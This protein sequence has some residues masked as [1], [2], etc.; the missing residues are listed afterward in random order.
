[1]AS[2]PE[3][4]DH[5]DVMIFSHG[6]FSR[7]FIARWCDLPLQAGYHFAADAGGVSFSFCNLDGLVGQIPHLMSLSLRFLDTN[8]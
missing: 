4:V 2:C 1:M 7:V 5:S 3:E 6:H 8:I